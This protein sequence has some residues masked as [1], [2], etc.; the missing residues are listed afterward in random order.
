M[1]FG[2]YVNSKFHSLLHL[3]S[4]LILIN[5]LWFLVSAL[6]LFVF[7]IAPAT[8]G[9]Y[10]VT[11]SR[12]MG[13]DSS[14]FRGFFRVFKREFWKSQRVFISFLLIGTII[15]VDVYYFYMSFTADQSFFHAFGLFV[16]VILVLL[17]LLSLIHIGPV[18]LHFPGLSTF[19]LVK[20]ALLFSVGF[21]FHSFLIIIIIALS[22][23]LIFCFPNLFTL[24]PTILVS[25]NVYLA[26]YIVKGRYLR[27]IKNPDSLLIAVLR[28]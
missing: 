7:T 16:S 3:L 21:L 6:G 17:Y 24:I 18:Y 15:A 28:E 13:Y 10:T 26:L 27:L 25:L 8:I 5:V 12:I 11:Y 9:M 23:A 20:Y 14:I 1:S 19:Q 22:L 2:E 4:D